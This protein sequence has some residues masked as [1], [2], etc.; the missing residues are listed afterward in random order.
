[1]KLCKDC[2]YC[3]PMQTGL[4]SKVTAPLYEYAK[5]G[6]VKTGDAKVL[7]DGNSSVYC[8]EMRRKSRW[9]TPKCGPKGNWFEAKEPK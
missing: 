6:N 3:Q 8:H 4:S 2:K 7:V 1:M 9:F 5:C